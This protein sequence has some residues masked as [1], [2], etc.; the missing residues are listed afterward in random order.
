MSHKV[1]FG[2]K[3][4]YN[5]FVGCWVPVLVSVLCY[6]SLMSSF[7]RV[8]ILLTL[9]LFPLASSVS[10][11]VTRSRTQR[12]DP[13]SSST[14]FQPVMLKFLQ[15]PSLPCSLP[16]TLPSPGQFLLLPP[17]DIHSLFPSTGSTLAPGCQE[18]LLKV[19]E[20]KIVS[21]LSIPI[22]RKLERRGGAESPVGG[23]GD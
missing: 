23:G 15:G 11:L 8:L 7:Y 10:D 5:D 1:H 6:V 16:S 14:E 2:L 9:V 4:S 18:L 3:R 21:A 19:R 22:P 12:E 13:G 17:S 20:A